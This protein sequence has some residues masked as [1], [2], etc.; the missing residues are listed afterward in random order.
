MVLPVFLE[1]MGCRVF[2]DIT[3]S[4]EYQGATAEIQM[5]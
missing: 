2:L 5:E 3:V 4:Q 1:I